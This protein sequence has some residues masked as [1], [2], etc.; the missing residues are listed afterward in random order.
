MARPTSVVNIAVRAIDQTKAGLT[1]PIKNIQ[2]LQSSLNKL[3]PAAI[4]VGGALTAAFAATAKSLIDTRQKMVEF[5]DRIG[6]SVSALSS[7]KFA[8][9]Q[10]GVA[11][12]ALQTSL[13]RMV[14]RVSEASMGTGEAVKALD[15]LGV[16]AQEIAKL[17]P[18]A[19]FQAIARAFDGIEDPGRRAAIAMKL[20]DTE[21][22][23]LLQILAG[24][25]EGL[26]RMQ[27]QAAA[28]G[29]TMS[30]QTARGVQRMNESLG[31][32]KAG[33]VGIVNQFL[34]G[35]L[36]ALNAINQPAATSGLTAIQ[37]T[38]RFIGEQIG[39][40]ITGFQLLF[41]IVSR[42]LGN[43]G[44]AVETVAKLV[45]D[46]FVGAFRV[47]VAGMEQSFAGLI[48]FI[49][50]Q[51]N[52]L[53]SKVPAKLRGFLGLDNAQIPKLQVDT[54]DFQKAS[55][56]LSQSIQGNISDIQVYFEVTKQNFREIGQQFDAL[57]QSAMRAQNQGLSGTQITIPSAPGV[58][59][60][61]EVPQIPPTPEGI[62]QVQ[63]SIAQTQVA[64]TDL[65]QTVSSGL[66]GALGA[67][68][69]G[70]QK[71]GEAFRQM[72]ASILGSIGQ[73][74][75]QMIVLGI[76]Q[77]TFNVATA[78]TLKAAQAG[79]QA[80]Y[81]AMLPTLST[82]ATL[83]AIATGG[84]S[85]SAA[86]GVPIAVASNNAIVTAVSGLFSGLAKG[87][88]LAGQAHDGLTMVPREGTY[89]LDE[90][91]RVLSAQQNADLIEFMGQSKTQINLT[92]DGAVL[93][94]VITNLFDRG[95]V[96]ARA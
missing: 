45:A 71:A 76:T 65:S 14:R 70:A 30:D 55:D 83:S 66:G 37:D 90:G 82:A 54:S 61:P 29:I 49:I 33:L 92:L 42:V 6:I 89:L 64:M 81:A 95:L 36:P 84:A 91:E 41:D 67:V 58:I 25:S 94:S 43:I 26:E 50:D 52:G 4:A 5:S 2:D 31:I 46:T 77:K 74:I 15:E 44:L 17:R 48:N 9:E 24:G 32:L 22:V 87:A 3:K 8:A 96:E 88:G 40:A 60:G 86:A 47:A 69:S 93:G 85:L 16:S 34:E 38:M 63:E 68:F 35:F 11:F 59:A 79:A 51:I 39:N 62:T 75:G 73:I 1:T 13:Q 18:E 27:A 21:G 57:G 78:A 56:A 28:L 7:L 20:F 23:Q 10:N 12:S 53:A 72:G 80:G 19:Q